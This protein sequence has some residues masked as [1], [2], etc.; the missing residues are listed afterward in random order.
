[1]THLISTLPREQ[2]RQQ[3]RGWRA[4]AARMALWYDIRPESEPLPRTPSLYS[5]TVIHKLTSLSTLHTPHTTLSRTTPNSKNKTI[6]QCYSGLY[7]YFKHVHMRRA[8]SYNTTSSYTASSSSST[9]HVRCKKK[10]Q[11]RPVSLAPSD[12]HCVRQR[13]T[14]CGNATPSSTARAASEGIELRS[15]VKG[16]IPR[17]GHGDGDGDGEGRT[18]RRGGGW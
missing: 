12:R 11:K 16:R 10:R 1:M 13:D 8:A 3:H 9:P 4:P 7:T 17:R 18:R 14:V 5:Q 6:V 15:H 2:T